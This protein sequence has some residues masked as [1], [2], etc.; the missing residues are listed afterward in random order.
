MGPKADGSG[1]KRWGRSSGQ[2][3]TVPAGFRRFDVYA[4]MLQLFNLNQEKARNTQPVRVR[5][6]SQPKLPASQETIEA[7]RAALAAWTAKLCAATLVLGAA[8]YDALCY[9]GPWTDDLVLRLRFDTSLPKAL[10]PSRSKR[11]E[12][13]LIVSS[14][15]SPAFTA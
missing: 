5:R 14:H 1:G 7:E 12:P 2:G 15:G 6:V 8:S 4:R 10:M 13:R 9:N 3:L 11:A